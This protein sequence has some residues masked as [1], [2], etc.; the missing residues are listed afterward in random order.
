MLVK[1]LVGL[2]F[3]MCPKPPICS[4]IVH[5]ESKVETVEIEMG[6]EVFRTFDVSN[7][8]AEYLCLKNML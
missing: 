8:G 4:L 7:I 3:S 5:G 1:A 6:K 2:L